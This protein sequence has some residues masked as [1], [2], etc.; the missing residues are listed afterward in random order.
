MNMISKLLIALFFIFSSISSLAGEKPL[1]LVWE[2]PG[3][4]RP[5]C[6][7]A[8][9]IIARRAGFRVRKVGP[10]FRDFGLFKKAKLWVQPGGKSTTAAAAMG[11][12]MMDEIREFVRNGGGYVGFCAGMFIATPEIG[13][14][15][16]VG[17]GI[18]PGETELLIKEGPDRAMMPIE[19][20]DHGKVTMY[21]A[22]GPFM[23]VS[24]SDLKAAGGEVIARYPDGKIAGIR[25][26]YG[27]GK[28]AVIGAH[29][30][31]GFL[32]K[33]GRGY[34]DIRG[35]RFFVKDMVRYATSP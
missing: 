3:A 9:V 26:R 23:R 14:S 28:V 15:K 11:S 19:T 20:S 1:A 31:A 30:E 8:S 4:C 18:I 5:S 33:L 22:G 17:F 24:D 32:W 6:L 34:F 12:E 13:T 27:K 10:G 21:F 16:K 7:D 29:P 35:E 2:G 25:A